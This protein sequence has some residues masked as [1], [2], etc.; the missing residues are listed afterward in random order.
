MNMEK[1]HILARGE[2]FAKQLLF[3]LRC[4]VCDEIVT[5]F[6]HKICP[7]CIAKR[8][9]LT[10]PYC[11]KC[12][13]KVQEQR[14]LC[15]DCRNKKHLFFRG[16]A[17]YEYESIAGS[18]YRFKYGGRQEYAEFYG[19]EMANLLGDFVRGIKPDAL[20]PIPLHK[21]RQRKRGYNQAA[22]LART[23][24][25][26]LDVPVLEGYLLRVKNTMPLKRLNPKERQ[27]NLKKAFKIAQNDVKLKTVMVV[28]DI[29]TTGSTVDEAAETLLDCGVE[30]VCFVAL[31]CGAGV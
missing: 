27:N 11:M 28:D 23:L 13:K 17:L 25:R 12:G 16:R 19:E 5:P 14:E 22:L 26:R 29:Y 1:T 7:G 2:A 10:S 20:I 4:P 9:I 3:P 6:G 24:G 8:K 30:R 18:I 21:S 31:A 15:E